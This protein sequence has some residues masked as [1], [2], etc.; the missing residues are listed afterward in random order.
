MKMTPTFFALAVFLMSPLAM[1]GDTTIEEGK[2]LYK[3]Y[4]SACHGATGGMDMS[5]RLAPPI[6]GVRFHYISSHADK[7]SFVNAIT[8]W[9]A[10]PEASRALMPG[11]IRKFKLMPSIPVTKENA[12]KIATYIFEGQLEKLPGFD[13]HFE[14]MHGK[15]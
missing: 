14:K 8:E 3:T 10:K 2:Q 4:C 9:L 13:E 15:K 7:A 1:A 12:E 11:A 6:A 5:K